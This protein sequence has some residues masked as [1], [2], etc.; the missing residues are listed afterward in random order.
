MTPCRDG[1]CLFFVQTNGIFHL[2][3]TNDKKEK[4]VWTIDMK[5][6]GTVYK[7]EAK[8]KA[9]VTLIMTDDIFTQLSE[10]KACSR[11]HS[12]QDYS[13]AILYRSTVKRLS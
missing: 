9:D 13:H 1:H 10:G 2:E 5:K 12:L 7:G 11:V 3:I 4:A 8:P 6:T